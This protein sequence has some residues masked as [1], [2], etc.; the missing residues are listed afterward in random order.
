MTANG[1]DPAAMEFLERFFRE[2]ERSSGPVDARNRLQ[3]VMDNFR[4]ASEA[5]ELTTDGRDLVHVSYSVALSV[6]D[7]FAST[8]EGGGNG[9]A[10]FMNT[11]EQ[12]R[13]RA[14]GDRLRPV[15]RALAG[16]LTTVNDAGIQSEF[17]T[18]DLAINGAE[19]GAAIGAV[20]SYQRFQE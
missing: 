17:G 13:F 5:G 2:L 8:D 20:E 12:E 7:Y 9:W 16:Y 11:E 15:N 14:E 3:S 19:Y 4:T 10:D 1:Y 6:L 18:H